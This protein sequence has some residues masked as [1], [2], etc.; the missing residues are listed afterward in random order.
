[1]A[2]LPF[3]RGEGA[4]QCLL[5]ANANDRSES[6][7]ARPL[8]GGVS[9]KT[10]R[11]DVFKRPEFPGS[12]LPHGPAPRV[13]G[14]ERDARSLEWRAGAQVVRMDPM[15]YRAEQRSRS[16]GRVGVG[17]LVELAGVAGTSA[18]R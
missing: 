14:G 1:V 18:L 3:L 11:R 8:T 16:A 9:A 17:L 7:S 12:T 2:T 4:P 6:D 13:P 15:P 10:C 5:P